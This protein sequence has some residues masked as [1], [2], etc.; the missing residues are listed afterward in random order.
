MDKVTEGLAK[1]LKSQP[2]VQK[3]SPDMK[4]E[5]LPDGVYSGMSDEDYNKIEALRSTE[6]KCFVNWKGETFPGKYYANYIYKPFKVMKDEVTGE[7]DVFVIGN[8]VHEKVLFGTTDF[9]THPKIFK[10]GAAT[11]I[12]NR[13]T[14]DLC[15]SSLLAR[16]LFR[17]LLEGSYRELVVI[18]TCPATGLRLKAKMDIVD[19]DLQTITDIKT[20]GNLSELTTTADWKS[21]FL[22][23][24]YPIQ[25]Q[26]YLYCANLAFGDPLFGAERKMIFAA[27]EKGKDYDV[28]FLQTDADKREGYHA[29]FHNA[30]KELAMRKKSNNWFDQIK[31]I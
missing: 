6:S 24:G 12:K 16:P 2:L 8:K 15:A 21:G 31:I 14:V 10:E 7:K 1:R 13:N 30:L 4:A 20:T 3:V 28:E 25:E 19:S 18:V 23:Y 11:R 9:N 22:N 26:H 29:I 17:N 5:E 27:V